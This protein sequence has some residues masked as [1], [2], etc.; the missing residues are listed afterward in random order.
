MQKGFTIYIF[1]S[2]TV[3]FNIQYFPMTYLN[4]TGYYSN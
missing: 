1:N 3:I 2:F 4:K